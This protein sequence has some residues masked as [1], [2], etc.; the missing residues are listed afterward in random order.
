[1]Y[2]LDINFILTPWLLK[3][4]SHQRAEIPLLVGEGVV[5]GREASPRDVLHGSDV[6]HVSRVL[7]LT[8]HPHGVGIGLAGLEWNFKSV[9]QIIRRTLVS[10]YLYLASKSKDHFRME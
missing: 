8:G 10:I 9:G 1:M 3:K 6:L 7:A 2:F 5:V 4:H